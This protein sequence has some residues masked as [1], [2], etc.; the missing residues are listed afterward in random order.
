MGAFKDLGTE[1]IL[2]TYAFNDFY[3]AGAKVTSSHPRWA[4]F[5]SSNT[6]VLL[7]AATSMADSVISDS[8]MLS[9]TDYILAFS[10]DIAYKERLV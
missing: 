3:L 6:A 8:H 7:C 4:V 5:D 2:T 1:A 9:D 10:T